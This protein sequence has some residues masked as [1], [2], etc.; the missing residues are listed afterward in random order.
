MNELDRPTE[1]LIRELSSDLA[2]VAAAGSALWPAALMSIIS[3]VAVALVFAAW[4]G[5][6]PGLSSLFAQPLFQ[7]REAHL[8]LAALF[9]A[10]AI[11]TL[12]IPGRSTLK[13]QLL[14]SLVLPAALALTLLLQ[15]ALA[16]PG[17]LL[18]LHLS[19]TACT[20]AILAL[21]VAPSALL[22]LQ[23]R[24]RATTS[25][26]WTGALIG[27]TTS[28]FAS[29]ALSLHCPNDDPVHLLTWHLLLPLMIAAVLGS[30]AGR[31]WL[32]W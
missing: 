5:L 2:P 27:A 3:I 15:L 25:P 21:G 13:Y 28:L 9:A 17:A 10:F 18:D 31:R 4:L 1:T 11:Q 6:R 16:Q 8:L 22:F 32:R 30:L 12:A 14:C 19:E 26:A 7:V 29:T 24:R 23:I 20:E